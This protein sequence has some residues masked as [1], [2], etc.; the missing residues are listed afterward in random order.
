MVEMVGL[1][2]SRHMGVE[3]KIGGFYHPNHPF[4]QGFP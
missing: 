4:S 1:V 3:P 2:G